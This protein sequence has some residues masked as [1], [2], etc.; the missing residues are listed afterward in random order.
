MACNR[1]R[2]GALARIVLDERR[3]FEQGAEGRGLAADGVSRSLARTLFRACDPRAAQAAAERRLAG[4]DRQHEPPPPSPGCEQSRREMFEKFG[5]YQVFRSAFDEAQRHVEAGE[6]SPPATP[7]ALVRESVMVRVL[8]AAGCRARA[9]RRLYE[10][11]EMTGL[12]GAEPRRF[13]RQHPRERRSRSP[14]RAAR[15]GGGRGSPDDGSGQSGPAGGRS[16]QSREQAS[17]SRR[18]RT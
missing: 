3:R 17:R 13:C 15:Q 18:C 6:L 4:W 10:R 5:G 1:V 11:H 7:E 14:R 12:L 16:R 2:S 9:R 8:V